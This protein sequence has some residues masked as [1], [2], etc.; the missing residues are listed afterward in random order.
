MPSLRYPCFYVFKDTRDEWRWT[1][2]GRAGDEIASSTES[3]ASASDCM[4]SIKAIQ[5]SA[6]VEIFREREDE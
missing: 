1:F 5:D 2:Y 4:P 6:T 3:Y